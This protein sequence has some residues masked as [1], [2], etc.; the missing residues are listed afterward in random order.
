MAT[1]ITPPIAISKATVNLWID[2]T[3]LLLAEGV[4]QTGD[5]VTASLAQATTQ[6]GLL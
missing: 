4:M 2:L 1:T 5:T 3:N 6:A